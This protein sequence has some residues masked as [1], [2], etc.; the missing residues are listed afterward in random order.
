MGDHVQ[1]VL[2]VFRQ[3]KM[4][5]FPHQVRWDSTM[6]K[7]L[8]HCPGFYHKSEWRERIAPRNGRDYYQHI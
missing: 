4:S 7:N 8:L 5:A 3:Y 6:E 1:C 2:M